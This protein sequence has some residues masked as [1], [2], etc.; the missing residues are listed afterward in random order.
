MYENSLEK[1]EDTYLIHCLMTSF[2]MGLKI[3]IGIV[4]KNM[5]IFKFTRYIDFRFIY[6]TKA[7]VNEGLL[8]L[9]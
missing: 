4:R 2:F 6:M 5:E 1:R 8:N 9:L 7:A 3:G